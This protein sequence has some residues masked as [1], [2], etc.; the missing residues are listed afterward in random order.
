MKQGDLFYRWLFYALAAAVLMAV[1][2]LALNGLRLWGVHPFLPP[3]LVGAVSACEDRQE[4]LCA[5]AIFG[6]ACDLLMIAVI[7]CFYTLTFA[8]AALLAGLIARRLMM[9]GLLCST[10]SALLALLLHGVLY[11]LFLS[12]SHIVT[13]PAAAGLIGKEILLSLPLILPVYLLLRPIHLRF[14]A[15]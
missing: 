6:L 8:S 15:E 12:Y 14:R 1:Q 2:S 4:S 10:V 13:F 7:P 9:P 5:A 11:A 3:V